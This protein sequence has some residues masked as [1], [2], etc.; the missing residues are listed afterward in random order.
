MLIYS[1]KAHGFLSYLKRIYRFSF[2][3]TLIVT[4]RGFFYFSWFCYFDNGKNIT[5]SPSHLITKEK[6][7]CRVLLTLT[8]FPKPHVFC[9]VCKISTIFWWLLYLVCFKN[10]Y[11]Y[12]EISRNL[13]QP[14][15]LYRNAFYYKETIPELLIRLGQ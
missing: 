5:L 7:W 1:L 2:C 6:I 13:E 11:Y 10:K 4:E 9:L 14:V 12:L 8:A 15:N 3:E